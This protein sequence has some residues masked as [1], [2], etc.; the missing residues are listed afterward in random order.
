MAVLHPPEGSFNKAVLINPGMGGQ[1]TDQASI[2]A[3]RSFD[4]TDAAVVGRVNIAD[5]ESSPLPG[6]T[7]RAEGTDPALVGELR[8]GV[9][10]V[11]ELAQLAGAKELLDGRHQGLGVHQLGRGEGIGFPHGH[12]FFNDP[13][14]AV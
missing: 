13:L 7:P 2:G 11:H 5:G 3:F 4:R 12:P 14:E 6:K 1:G 10:L 8:Q 9:G